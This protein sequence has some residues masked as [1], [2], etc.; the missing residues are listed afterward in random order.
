MLNIYQHIKF[1]VYIG[2]VLTTTVRITSNKE[3]I[4]SGEDTCFDILTELYPSASI[5]RQVKF[6]TLMSDE[7]KDTLGERQMKETLD[8]V[9][10]EASGDKIVVRVQDRHHKGKRTDDVDIIQKQMLE[11]NKCKVVDVWYNEC[12]NIFLEEKNKQFVL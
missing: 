3:Y 8:I 12:P 6:Y 7:F 1:K 5:K 9:I 10:F 2:Q 4:G 11:W